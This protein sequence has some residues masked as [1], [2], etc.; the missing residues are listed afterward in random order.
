MSDRI[1]IIKYKRLG[2]F[3]G[4]EL[5]D[6]LQYKGNITVT[7]IKDNPYCKEGETINLHSYMVSDGI[8]NYPYDSGKVKSWIGIE[9]LF[10]FFT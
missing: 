3:K 10:E 1:N 9:E 7:A 4:T 8:M 2:D 6:K 5:Y